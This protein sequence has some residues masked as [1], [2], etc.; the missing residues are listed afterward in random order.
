MYRYQH[1]ESRITKN[2][3]SMTPSK[4]GNKAPIPE[5]E[6]MEIFGLSDKEFRLTLIRKEGELQENTDRPLKKTRKTM[7][8]Q[9]EKFD[10]EIATIKKK[11]PNKQTV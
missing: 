5:P 11:N 6:Q 1:K 7:H 8:E 9:N 2:Q 10:K 3:V 4:E